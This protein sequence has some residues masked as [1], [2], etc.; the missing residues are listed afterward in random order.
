M[1][2][3]LPDE[4]KV[5][6]GGFFIE[7]PVALRCLAQLVLI[8]QDRL[9]RKRP[10]LSFIFANLLNRQLHEGQRV[11]SSGTKEHDLRRQMETEFIGDPAQ[12]SAVSLLALSFAAK[13]DATARRYGGVTPPHPSCGTAPYTPPRYF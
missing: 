5:A 12:Q 2:R 3:A 1:A 9:D 8:Q 4:L 7:Q 11:S 13:K 6:L 10:T